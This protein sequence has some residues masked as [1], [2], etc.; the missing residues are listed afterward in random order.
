MDP[1]TQGAF[2]AVFAQTQGN[3][4][5]LAKAAVI[6]GLAGMAPDLDVLI[7]STDDSLLTLQYHRHFTHSLLFIPFG[8]LICSLFFHPL[9]GRRFGITFLQTLL[10]CIIG[11][12]THGLLDGCT[13]YGTQLLWPLTD[14]RFAWD[15]IPIIDPLVTLPLLTLIILSART[16]ARRYAVIGIVWL[17]LYFGFSTYQHQRALDEGQKLA[18]SRGLVIENIEAKP[19]FAN[20]FIW[21]IITTTEDSY[22]VDA[23]KIGWS[24]PTIWEGNTVQKLSI[25]RDLPWLNKNSQQAKDI[26]RFRW[27][28]TGYIALDKQNS[29]RVVD[30]RYSLLPQ[31]IEPL[32]GIELSPTANSEQYVE[33]YNERGDSASAIKQL[34]KMIWNSN[35]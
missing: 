3:A 30:I 34:W 9:L 4:K 14:K 32:W 15:I 27:F 18:E 6:G 1:I 20:I 23:V 16:K 13:S 31:Q 24:K 22:Y 35:W 21:K 33:F 10:W 2:G 19:S 5:D 17:G 25:D 8:G 29:N 28:S 26:E 12:A 11:F 7:R